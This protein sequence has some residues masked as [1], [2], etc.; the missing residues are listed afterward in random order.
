M[1][2]L[3]PDDATER[4][5]QEARGQEDR[6]SQEARGQEDRTAALATAE[7]ADARPR[8]PMRKSTPPLLAFTTPRR[9]APRP[10]LPLPLLATTSPSTSAMTT[11]KAAAVA[12][13]TPFFS[14]K[15]KSSSTSIPKQF[16]SRTSAL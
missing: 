6:I 11:L 1:F 2:L 13:T 12:S 3:G 16:R 15:P 4:A 8:L 14:K 10:M 5:A 7:A 9:V